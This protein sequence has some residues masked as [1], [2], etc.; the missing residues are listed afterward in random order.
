MTSSMAAGKNEGKV[1]MAENAAKADAPPMFAECD[2][3]GDNGNGHDDCWALQPP[4]N[5]KSACPKNDL[6]NSLADAEQTAS[7]ETKNDDSSEKSKNMKFKQRFE[8][9]F[10]TF[11]AED[12]SELSSKKLVV[13]AFVKSF[14]L[15]N[16]SLELFWL[17]KAK[18]LKNP[19]HQ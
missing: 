14:S 15:I 13:S 11:D 3:W 18:R 8:P 12:L 5:K 9:Y 6:T 2:N 7:Q 10:L 1:K 19:S 4:S 17:K 16:F